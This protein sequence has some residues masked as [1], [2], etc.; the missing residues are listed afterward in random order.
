MNTNINEGT[1]QFDPDVEEAG[2]D[3]DLVVLPADNKVSAEVE[4]DTKTNT[5]KT[6]DV[7][8]NIEEPSEEGKEPPF[9]RSL[10]SRA[11]A[12][13]SFFGPLRKSAPAPVDKSSE[14]N[15]TIID[16]TKNNNLEVPDDEKDAF[17]PETKN[18][19][20]DEA[21]DFDDAEPPVQISTVAGEIEEEMPEVPE[22]NFPSLKPVEEINIPSTKT[23]V[24]S[25]IDDDADSLPSR[26][27]IVP[28]P[29]NRTLSGSV[30][31]LKVSDA[32]SV[33]SEALLF[34][35][36]EEPNMP[37]NS[38]ALEE[39]E[40]TGSLQPPRI[41]QE[42]ALRHQSF[43]GIDDDNVSVVRKTFE[44]VAQFNTDDQVNHEE[45]V[46]GTQ[47]GLFESDTFMMVGETLFR[48]EYEQ[49]NNKSKTA[50]RRRL[51][52]GGLVFLLLLVPVA[53]AFLRFNKRSSVIHLKETEKGI[54]EREQVNTQL[55][56]QQN[57][58]LEEESLGIVDEKLLSV[59]DEFTL[60]AANATFNVFLGETS[61]PPSTSKMTDTASKIGL[62]FAPTCTFRACNYFRKHLEYLELYNNYRFFVEIYLEAIVSE[63]L[64][65]LPF[66]CIVAVFVLCGALL[67][68]VYML[69]SSLHSR[70]QKPAAVK[71]TTN[72]ISPR[73]V[74]KED[75]RTLP[76][77]E[78]EAGVEPLLVSL[79]YYQVLRKDDLKAILRRRE[80]PVGGVKD[81][82][83]M[84]LVKDYREELQELSYKKLQSRLKR[85]GLKQTGKKE[86]LIVRLLETGFS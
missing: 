63:F 30:L 51:F 73:K 48:G 58:T 42:N 35:D 54:V 70:N 34:T 17:T 37:E 80:L 53:A 11:S 22:G 60:E 71:K 20:P 68:A 49:P 50:R 19:V 84:R 74:K 4:S 39:K 62:S 15:D 64:E 78:E 14:I 16:A 69:W 86:D 66:I 27:T 67:G 85:Q 24:V 43:F 76:R 3:P 26:Q 36:M 52:K 21:Q 1:V 38:P 56:M 46:E 13:V 23:P 5:D 2:H 28:S 9:K 44:R 7:L 57:V 31:S 41:F 45:N 83:I 61:A 81:E 8:K 77:I 12:F 75:K 47:S 55:V 6:G 10:P 32:G 72:E 40:E 33:M 18:E 59:E 65:R 25:S 79:E 82:L 29:E